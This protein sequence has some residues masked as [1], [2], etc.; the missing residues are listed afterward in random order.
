MSID[1]PKDKSR[2]VPR[3][4]PAGQPV[5]HQKWGKL[6]FMHWPIEATLLR[7]LVPE[8]LEIDQFEGKAWIAIAPFTIWDMRAFPPYLP[9]LPGLNHMHE[10]NV[11]TYVRFNDEPGVWFFSLDTNSHAAV[12]GGRTLFKLPYYSA[13]IELE[14]TGDEI[15]Y[16]LTRDEPPQGRF[17]AS[18]TI[19]KALPQSQA[20]S[21]E[22]FLTERYGLFTEHSGEIYRAQLEHPP[23]PLREAT[24]GSFDSNLI[25]VLGLEAPRGAPLTH[26]A[27]ALGVDI[28]F[29][30]KASPDL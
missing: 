24:L 4:P 14:Q 15:T 9:A 10:L 30:R 27:E 6:L 18:W 17:T 12:F 1:V 8:A 5:I 2:V 22:F 19:G 25:T 28:W 26:Y 7:P 16:S 21:R 29:L 23:W 13:E 3:T 11:R 20:G